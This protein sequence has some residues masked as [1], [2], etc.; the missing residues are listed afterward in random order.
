MNAVNTHA[1]TND[2]NIAVPGRFGGVPLPFEGYTTSTL[3]QWATRLYQTTA[4]LSS[5]KPGSVSQY[6]QL[7][8]HVSDTLLVYNDVWQGT[9]LPLKPAFLATQVYTLIESVRRGAVPRI[10]CVGS[11]RV[12]REDW[13][14]EM[15]RC[16]FF[17][18]SGSL[19]YSPFF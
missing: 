11:T 1:A 13:Q 7:P 18:A 19:C 8:R 4:L 6:N 5:L 2:C 16:L 10:P 15:Q 12:I 17:G 14:P 9:G 3:M